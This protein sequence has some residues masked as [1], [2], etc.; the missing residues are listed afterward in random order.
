MAV[1]T[2]PPASNHTD[3]DPVPH[4]DI[5]FG[6][7]TDRRSSDTCD[8]AGGSPDRSSDDWS[9]R[10]TAP[11]DHDELD[12]ADDVDSANAVECMDHC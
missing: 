3:K 5:D 1:G 2:F 4:R 6:R 7:S 9:D 10:S 12:I 11:S 8:F